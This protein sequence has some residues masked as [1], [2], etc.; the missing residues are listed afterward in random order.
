MIRRAGPWAL[1]PAGF[2]ALA[3]VVGRLS[4]ASSET[5][6]TWLVIGG[7]ALAA[8]PLTLSLVEF[9]RKQPKYA[10]ARALD[11]HYGLHDRIAT[12]LSFS[13]I[14][15][16]GRTPFMNLAIDDASA[17]AREVQPNEAV[18]L[19]SPRQIWFAVGLTLL[20]SALWFVR[21][22]AEMAPIVV[23]QGRPSSLTP[24]DAI[25]IR[26]AIQDLR[27]EMTDPKLLASADQ[28]N[29][30]IEQLSDQELDEREAFRRLA[31]V[32]KDLQPSLDAAVLDRMLVDTAQKLRESNLARPA[33]DA[34]AKHKLSEAA[35][36]L[37]KLSEKLNAATPPA[38]PASRKS[39]AKR[40]REALEKALEK[41]S[42]ER[43]Q[44]VR[45]LEGQR[46]EL[47]A[48]RKRLLKRKATAAAG[49]RAQIQSRLDRTRRQLE[50]LSREIEGAKA[51]RQQM[52]ELDRELAEAAKALSK[53]LGGDD[54]AL[55]R[56]GD[57]LDRIQR[58][59][60]TDEQKR[61][62]LRRVNEIRDRLKE[63]GPEARQHQWRLM[64]FQD[65][66]GGRKPGSGK[67]GSG[68]E[69]GEGTGEATIQLIP[70]VG[71]GESGDALGGG[72]HAGDEPG[73]DVRGDPTKTPE[74]KL[75]VP[76]VG[77]P[78][79]PGPANS[80]VIAG[81]AHEGFVAPAYEEVYRQYK[82]VAEEVINQDDI[83]PGYRVY[84]RRYFEL[85]RPRA[86]VK[87]PQGANVPGEEQNE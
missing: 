8:V 84:V 7:A 76:I 30:V 45:R 79:G 65:R 66:A 37:R 26:E 62:L 47:L 12:A 6:G 11:R 56:A 42:L 27:S 48:S 51:A 83:P 31:A 9:F 61:E 18:P 74:T 10:G 4:R 35:K 24:D 77:L 67:P 52:S 80:N 49:E 64:R 21:L 5:I 41:A 55:R 81:A 71:P 15:A 68:S 87:D 75:D 22:P 57:E 58:Q 19:H 29:R 32:E 36:E 1:L 82:H 63:G 33:A 53:E 28:L 50:R 25:G 39:D 34:I 17:F 46:Q 78:A 72:K 40:S 2:C 14:P 16:E 43:D 69:P 3:V 73:P 20:A 70:P 85:I 38:S 23:V 60:L 86:A 44:A 54:Q 59:R 13:D